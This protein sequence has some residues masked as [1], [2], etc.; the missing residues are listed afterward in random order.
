[1]KRCCIQT[2]I[3]I[4]IVTTIIIIIKPLGNSLGLKLGLETACACPCSVTREI[5]QWFK[6]SDKE[7]ILNAVICIFPF[8]SDEK[9]FKSRKKIKKNN[10]QSVPVKGLCVS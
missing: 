7:K 2:I 10:K 4:T 3:L 6:F 1:M 9:T 5:L 8:M